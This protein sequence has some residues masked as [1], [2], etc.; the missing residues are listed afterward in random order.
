M[1]SSII[2]SVVCRRVLVPRLT[3]LPQVHCLRLCSTSN[4]GSSSNSKNIAPED[5]FDPEVE[6]EKEFLDMTTSMTKDLGIAGLCTLHVSFWFYVFKVL[7]NGGVPCDRAPNSRVQNHGMILSRL[8][9]VLT[10][11]KMKLLFVI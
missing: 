6:K 9:R 4:G 1:M 7:H 11:T 5:F 2:R 3:S 8:W 10:M